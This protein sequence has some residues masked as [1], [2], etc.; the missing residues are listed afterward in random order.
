MSIEIR[1]AAIKDKY[2][3]LQLF[4]EF[5]VYLHAPDTP[6]KISGKIVDEILEREDMKIFIAL[7]N[8]KP[9]GIVTFFIQ[10]NIRHGDHRGH[11]EDFFVTEK[12][13]NKGIGSALITHIKDYCRSNKIKVIK[14]NSGIELLPAHVF[15]EKNGGKTT[16]KF[17]RFDIE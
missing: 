9:A 12:F 11:I 7:V 16:E 17:F 14:L 4:D 3:I 6:S 2:N 13:R 5:S 1:L 8:K 10:P 15:Y